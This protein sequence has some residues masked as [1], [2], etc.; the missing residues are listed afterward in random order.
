VPAPPLA[1]G[2]RL[3]GVQ[4]FVCS[5]ERWWFGVFCLRS[6]G[7]LI[8]MTEVESLDTNAIVYSKVDVKEA[9]YWI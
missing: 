9:Y 3:A 1:R 7:D 4:S 8:P 6:A 5:F 2:G